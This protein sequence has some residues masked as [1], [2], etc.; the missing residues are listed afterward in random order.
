MLPRKRKVVE[1]LFKNYAGIL[2]NLDSVRDSEELSEM[3]DVIDFTFVSKSG[4]FM[5]PCDHEVKVR[6]A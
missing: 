3:I 4:L 2:G 6:I 5:M 1:S